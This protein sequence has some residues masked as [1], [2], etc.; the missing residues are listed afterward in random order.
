[1]E[2]IGTSVTLNNGKTMPVLGLG[3]W[4]S[5]PG[6]VAR[7]VEHAL[8]VGYRHIDG[9]YLYANVIGNEKEV[10][11]GIRASGVALYIFWEY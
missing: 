7:A 11:E 9:A 10:G 4:K 3:T 6:E 2:N 8:K 1:M 5:A